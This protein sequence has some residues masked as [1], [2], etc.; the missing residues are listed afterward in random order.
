MHECALAVGAPVAGG[1]GIGG[2]DHDEG[3]GTV[4][5]D[6]NPDPEADADAD[7]DGVP[8][9]LFRCLDPE[10]V[11]GRALLEPNPN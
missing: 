11:M 1:R 9:D 10:F 2:D 8:D 5:A 6:P 4:D 7:A 3:E